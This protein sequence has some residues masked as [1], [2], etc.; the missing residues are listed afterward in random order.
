VNNPKPADYY[1]ATARSRVCFIQAF[2]YGYRAVAKKRVAYAAM[3]GRV[4]AESPKPLSPRKDREASLKS[5]RSKTE[6][7]KTEDTVSNI[8]E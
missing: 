2:G 7:R 6:S 4:I 8:A 5:W 3:I 1:L